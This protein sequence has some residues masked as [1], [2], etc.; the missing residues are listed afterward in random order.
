MKTMVS[1]RVMNSKNGVQFQYVFNGIMNS[2][3]VVDEGIEFNTHYDMIKFFFDVFN[4]EFNYIQNKKRYPNLTDRIESF[5]RGL[6]SCFRIDYWD[7]E[8]GKIGEKWGYCQTER[9][10]NDF[11]SNWWHMIAYRIIQIA[12]KVDYDLKNIY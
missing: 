8:I 4:E 12:N 1:E 9:K 2:S 6:P 7:D 3:R 5:L 10:R 11:I